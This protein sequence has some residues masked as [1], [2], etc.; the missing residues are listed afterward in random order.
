MQ[1]S[2]TKEKTIEL[3]EEVRMKNKK[4]LL[5][6]GKVQCI[7]CWKFGTKKDDQGEIIVYNICALNAGCS[8]VNKLVK[9]LQ[10]T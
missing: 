6:F 9:N 3:C 4:K 8:Q 10:K 5:S 7:F 1:Q 2:I